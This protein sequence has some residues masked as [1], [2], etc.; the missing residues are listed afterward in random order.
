MEIKLRKHQHALT[1]TGFA[2]IL[3]MVLLYLLS[4]MIIEKNAQPISMT[5][6][7]GYSDPEIAGLYIWTTSVVTVLL[8]LVTI[9]A[10]NAIMEL[11]FRNYLAARMTGWITY[12]IPRSV[13]YKMFLIGAVTYAA[14]AAFEIRKI[15][16]IPMTDALKDVM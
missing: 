16:A 2:V 1:I 5:K 3:F 14:V 10:V 7:L 4:R 6:I 13:F 12:D 9:P 15:R 8:L 11:I